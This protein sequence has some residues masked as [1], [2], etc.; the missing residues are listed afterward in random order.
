[1]LKSN[2]EQNLSHRR[3]EQD[4]AAGSRF[5]CSFA[6]PGG[7]IGQIERVAQNQA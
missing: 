1:M 4:K 3:V 5:A 7:E 2:H 6:C